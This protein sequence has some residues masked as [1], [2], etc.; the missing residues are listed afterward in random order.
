MLSRSLL[1]AYCLAGLWAAF[2]TFFVF[3]SGLM[4][5]PPEVQLRV[6]PLL[7]LAWIAFVLVWHWP[8]VGGAL[9]VAKGL[10]LLAIL[11]TF[12]RR[13]PSNDLFL[14][15]TLALPPIVSGVLFIN[16]GAHERA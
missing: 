12:F 14:I 2:W 9:L 5:A 16:S 10:G 1:L 8:R 15:L 11:F 4:G 7:V 13:S 3:A 6:V